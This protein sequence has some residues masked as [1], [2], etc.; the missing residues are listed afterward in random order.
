MPT[1]KGED[2]KNKTLPLRRPFPVSLLFWIVVLWVILGWLRFARV[3]IDRELILSLISPGLYR[4]LLLA[5]LSWGLVGL[6]LL[7]GILRRAPWTL[8]LLWGIAIFYP[9]VYWVERWLLWA[10]PNARQNWPFMLLLTGVWF[11]LVGWVAFSEKVRKYFKK[12]TI[13]G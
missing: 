6:P 10:D 8:N 2:P 7:W 13:E 5:G 12:A 1:S 11:G 3:I 4:Y 9:A